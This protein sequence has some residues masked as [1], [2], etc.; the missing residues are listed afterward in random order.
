VQIKGG[1]RGYKK[2]ARRWYKN[3]KNNGK[4]VVVLPINKEVKENESN[5]GDMANI[6]YYKRIESDL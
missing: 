2:S 6:T 5:H 3:D 1:E 4:N